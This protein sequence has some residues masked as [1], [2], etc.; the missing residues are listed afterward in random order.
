MAIKISLTYGN[1]QNRVYLVY[2]VALGVNYEIVL[3]GRAPQMPR[4]PFK[5][6]FFVRGHTQSKQSIREGTT[7]AVPM[8][9]MYV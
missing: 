7:A 5:L 6:S 2:L 9:I 4:Y 8:G 1:R 3:I